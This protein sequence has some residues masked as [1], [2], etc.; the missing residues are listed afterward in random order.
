M[1]TFLTLLYALYCSPLMLPS[2][3]A[4]APTAPSLGLPRLRADVKPGAALPIPTTSYVTD[5]LLAEDVGGVVR[6]KRRSVEYLSLDSGGNWSRPLRG[7]GQAAVSVSFLLLGSENTIIEVGG[8][9]L[10]VTAGLADGNLQLMYDDAAKGT[11][12][13]RSL[14]YYSPVESY[15]GQSLA[16]PPVLT[17]QIDPIGGV[18][19]LFAG[20]RL[21]ADNLRLIPN[22]EPVVTFRAGKEGAWVCGLVQADENPLYEDTNANGIDDGFE[23][24]YQGGQLLPIAAALHERQHLAKQWRTAQR[25]TR[26]PASL[27]VNRPVPDRQ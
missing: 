19:H 22:A 12:E 10:G 21:L 17:V 24:Q 3:A 15:D 14:G 7:A 11:P 25:T 18:W 20:T 23:R 5:G 26:P 8:A 2:G 1:K 6:E 4:A 9:R 27:S 13:W 16:A